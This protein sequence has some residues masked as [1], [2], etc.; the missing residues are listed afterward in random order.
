MFFDILKIHGIEESSVY[1][2]IFAKGLAAGKARAEAKGKAERARMLLLSL[3]RR[4]LGQPDE[5]VLA[6]IAAVGDR[7]RLIVLIHRILDA[8]TWDELL[9]W[10]DQSADGC[11]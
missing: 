9:A 5:Q 6:R 2:A 10:V 1:Q 4:K 3:G 11:Q 8:S 7:D